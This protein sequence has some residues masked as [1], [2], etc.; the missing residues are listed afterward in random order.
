[1]IPLA[2]RAGVQTAQY[3]EL[4]N[5]A[6]TGSLDIRSD[7]SGARI[8]IDGQARGTTP[9]T[10]R[11]LAPGD[12]Q[13]VIDARGRKVTQTVRVDAGI[14]GAAGGAVAKALAC[15]FACPWPSKFVRIGRSFHA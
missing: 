11:D 15:V 9:V 2:I 5:V 7:P 8:T 3:I 1:V 13:V 4:Q 10:V 6:M 12:H 14:T